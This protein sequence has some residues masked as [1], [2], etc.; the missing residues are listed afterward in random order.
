MK[1]GFVFVCLLSI[2]LSCIVFVSRPA[3]A[4][5]NAEGSVSRASEVS[6]EPAGYRSGSTS[7]SSDEADKGV[8]FYVK[9]FVIAAIIGLI[10][11]LIAVSVMKS[12]MKNVAK[13]RNAANYVDKDSFRLRVS[14]DSFL[15]KE[16]K[17]TKKQTN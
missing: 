5:R 16:E 6:A 4:K 11:A 7:G 13:S 8:G 9:K 2:V 10:V 1:K 14:E 3:Q 15:R 12:G 17:R